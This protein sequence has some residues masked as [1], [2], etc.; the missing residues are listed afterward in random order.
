MNH[1]M[2][3]LLSSPWCAPLWWCLFRQCAPQTLRCICTGAHTMVP[4]W[5]S[6]VTKTNAPNF[7]HGYLDPST[8]YDIFV[9]EIGCGMVIR[10]AWAKIVHVILPWKTKRPQKPLRAGEKV[11]FQIF[12]V[13]TD[14]TISSAM[15]I[16]LD[17]ILFSSQLLKL[18]KCE[19]I[20]ISAKKNKNENRIWLRR[21]NA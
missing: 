5:T 15:R 3:M 18:S 16:A 19:R 2:Q 11:R 13:Q 9:F 21:V 14:A 8:P 12:F 6:Y 1:R 20:R 4:L 7:E 17:L 10:S